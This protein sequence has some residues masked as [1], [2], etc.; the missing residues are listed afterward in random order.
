[1][2][3]ARLSRWVFKEGKRD[4]VFQELDSTF[5]DIARGAKGYRGVLSLLDKD[6]PNVGIVITLWTDED[7]FKASETGVLESAI[8]K[9]SEYLQEPPQVEKYRVFTAEL[10]QLVPS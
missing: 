4:E 7:S 2:V 5:G 1:M 9:V 3:V 6:Y 8:R 10:K